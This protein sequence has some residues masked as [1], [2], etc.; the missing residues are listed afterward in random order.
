MNAAGIPDTVATTITG[1][2]TLLTYKRY[3]IRQES[4]QRDALEKHEQYV[5]SIT[6]T[7]TITTGRK[8]G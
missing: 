1:H 8:A 6:G 3:G 2:R 5:Q 4:V 7:E